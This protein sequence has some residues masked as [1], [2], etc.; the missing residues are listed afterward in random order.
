MRVESVTQTACWRLPKSKATI[1]VSGVSSARQ[2]SL[3]CDGAD[4]R[5]SSSPSV[6][7]PSG[8]WL[9]FTGPNPTATEGDDP[10]PC[11]ATLTLI[12]EGCKFEW[13]TLSRYP[14]QRKPPWPG[15]GKEHASVSISG[16]VGV[17]QGGESGHVNCY[18]GPYR[19]VKNRV[20]ERRPTSQPQEA[21][22]E[23]TVGP[24][25]PPGDPHPL[26]RS[27]SRHQDAVVDRGVRHDRVP[28][29]SGDSCLASAAIGPA[30]SPPPRSPVAV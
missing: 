25:V 6:S 15:R 4:V 5:R 10:D 27:T 1:I 7:P 24:R 20:T 18:R 13:R 12:L 17:G 14:P 2:L 8:R 23:P 9:G 21:P 22:G 19:R 3:F 28:S 30:T 11:Y 26:C 29:Q 16:A